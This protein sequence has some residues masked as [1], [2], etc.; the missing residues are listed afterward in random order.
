MGVKGKP[1]KSNNGQTGNILNWFSSHEDFLYIILFH[2]LF[3]CSFLVLNQ[4][5]AQFPATL[6]LPCIHFLDWLRSLFLLLNSTCYAI[7]MFC[8]HFHWLL[9]VTQIHVRSRQ[10]F[11]FHV[12]KILQKIH[13]NFY[14]IKQNRLHFPVRVY[15]NR[16]Q[17]TSQHVKNS[18]HATRLSLVLYTFVLYT[19]WHHLWS[20][21]TW[22]NVIYLLIN[23]RFRHRSTKI[24]ISIGKFKLHF[25]KNVKL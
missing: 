17:K 8:V 4:I 1:Q 9:T 16:S 19:L 11:F 3:W 23:T 5:T 14:C 24:K 21:H 13:L 15:C 22:K 12:P 6:F 18:S 10:R 2:L 20:I 25:S 7:M